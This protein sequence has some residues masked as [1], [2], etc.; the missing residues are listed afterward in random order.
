MAPNTQRP[1]PPARRKRGA[2]LPTETEGRPLV[3]FASL[4]LGQ[5]YERF[6]GQPVPVVLVSLWLLGALILRAVAV[7]A[8]SALV[9]LWMWSSLAAPP[10]KDGFLFS[11]VRGRGIQRTSP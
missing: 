6:L 9:W 8:H 7:V 1:E 4:A 11:E 5:A 2:K 3:P 10:Y